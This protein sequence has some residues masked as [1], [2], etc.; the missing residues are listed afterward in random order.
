MLMLF[1]DLFSKGHNPHQSHHTKICIA[2]GLVRGWVVG[3]ALD[4][5]GEGPNFARWLG[6]LQ[7][8]EK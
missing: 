2:R 1:T 7:K 5:G 6:V 4:I 3:V 8:Y